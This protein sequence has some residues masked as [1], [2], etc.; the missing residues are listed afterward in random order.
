M[1]NL[2]FKS[3]KELREKLVK[4]EISSKELL[5]LFISRFK[6]FD[7]Q[8]NSAIEI[9]PTDSIKFE[10]ETGAL[11]GIPGLIKDNICQ[12]DRITS[13]SSKILSNPSLKLIGFLKMGRVQYQVLV[14]SSA[15]LLGF[16]RS[17]SM[18]TCR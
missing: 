9:F 18:L 2:A 10:N 4:K 5:D 8:L 16:K 15:E 11:S 12:Q 6:K 7:K 1:N 13:A 3:I 17:N 14:P